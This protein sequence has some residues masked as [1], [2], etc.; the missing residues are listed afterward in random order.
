ML[1][2]MVL[3]LLELKKLNNVLKIGIYEKGKTFALKIVKNLSIFALQILIKHYFFHY[4]CNIICIIK[5]ER[6]YLCMYLDDLWPKSQIFDK[7]G[8][9]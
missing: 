7:F 4:T 6:N 9:L 5:A 1:M 3:I 2:V 8:N